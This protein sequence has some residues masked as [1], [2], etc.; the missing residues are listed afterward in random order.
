MDCFSPS[1][2]KLCLPYENYIPAFVHLSPFSFFDAMLLL[3][4]CFVS[5]QSLP[6]LQ[7]RCNSTIACMCTK[8]KCACVNLIDVI[9]QCRHFIYTF[10]SPLCKVIILYRLIYSTV[11]H[12]LPYHSG[13]HLVTN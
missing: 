12:S 10:C 5:E 3:V 1:A 4:V 9:Q 11:R 8:N 7:G 13:K 6:I 2:C